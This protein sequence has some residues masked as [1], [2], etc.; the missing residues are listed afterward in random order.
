MWMGLL[1]DGTEM[2]HAVEEPVNGREFN[3]ANKMF[4]ITFRCVGRLD[5]TRLRLLQ[6]SCG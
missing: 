6:I 2:L 4:P 1:A 3:A 5:M